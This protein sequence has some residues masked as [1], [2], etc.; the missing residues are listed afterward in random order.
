MWPEWPGHWKN[1]L[2]LP[3][4]LSAQFTKLAFVDFNEEMFQ[5]KYYYQTMS[6]FLFQYFIKHTIILSIN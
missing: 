5:P 1:L 3:N 6:H 2:N 4:A